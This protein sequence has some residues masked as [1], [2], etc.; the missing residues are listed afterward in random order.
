VRAKR[1]Y[2]VVLNGEAVGRYDDL[3]SRFAFEP[4]GELRFM[5]RRRDRYLLVTASAAE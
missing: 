1:R 3:V 5:A 4:G 2:D